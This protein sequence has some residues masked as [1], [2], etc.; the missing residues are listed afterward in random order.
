MSGDKDPKDPSSTSAAYDVML[1]RWNMVNTLLG[2]TEAMRA[3]GT[4]YL[5]QHKRETDDRY[6]E[7]LR[8]SVLLNMTSKTLESLVGKPFQEPVKVSDDVPEAVQALLEDVD[9]QGNNLD[10]FCRCWFR[11]ALAK[12]FCHVLVDFPVKDESILTKED[13]RR[14]GLRPYWLLIKPEC[15]IDARATMVNGVE[16]L[17]HL[18]IAETYEEQVGF[19]TVVKQRIR[20]L[21]PGKAQLWEPTKE[22]GPGGKVVWSMVKE[23]PTGRPDIPLVT[24][25][26]NREALMLGKSPLEDLAHLNIAHWQGSSDQQHCMTVARF[27]ILACSGSGNPEDGDDDEITVGPDQV[28]YSRN[29][30]SKFYYVEHTGAA[31]EAGR[32]ELQDLEQQMAN[33]GAQFLKERPGS[34]TATAAAID[35]AESTSELGAWVQVFRDAVAQALYYTAQWLNLGQEETGTVELCTDWGSGEVSQPVL[36]TLQQARQE[37]DISRDTFVRALQEMG[38]LPED[39]D[40]E[41]DWKLL[42][43][44]AYR[45]LT[46]QD[47]QQLLAQFQAKGI[48]F[49]EYR[50]LLRKAG[51]ASLTDEA[52][53][54]EIEASGPSRSPGVAGGNPLPPGVMVPPLQRRPPVPPPT[55]A[56][57]P[58]PVNPPPTQ[59]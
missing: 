28:L 3:A 42:Q 38:V 17:T 36:S 9:L 27:P 14:A 32:K 13:E 45:L 41:E 20:V 5:P 58:P 12:S 52:A 55:P 23:W 30:N 25:Y 29:P 51:L 18:R 49:S 35:T 57:Q 8:T 54:N 24:F 19:T 15:V 11:E 39:F 40:P 56:N 59:G 53:K 46:A 22:K 44:E 37:K 2:G 7:R 4:A 50:E 43:G 21:E 48:A 26:T 34:E 1:P 6:Q 10:V 16:T 47:L 31:L 33:Y